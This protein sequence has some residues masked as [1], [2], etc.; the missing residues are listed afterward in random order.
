M[1][2]S[3]FFLLAAASA[4]VCFDLGGGRIPNLLNLYVLITGFAFQ[5]LK[6]GVPGLCASA[7]GTVLPFLLLYPFFRFRMLGGGDIKLLMA[8][9]AVVGYPEILNILLASFLAGGILSFFVLLFITGFRT[10]FRYF[11][12]YFLNNMNGQQRISYRKS[13]KCAENIH[14]SV[15]ILACTVLYAGGL[16]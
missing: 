5:F 13:G 9:G 16:I 11:R 1:P 15:P 2:I 12:N 10:R 8:F 4:A 7:A 6:S 14:F 3:G